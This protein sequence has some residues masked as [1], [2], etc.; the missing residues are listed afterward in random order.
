MTLLLATGS[1]EDDKTALSFWSRSLAYDLT[2]FLDDVVDVANVVVLD[3]VVDVAKVLVR[4]ERLL[5]P[6]LR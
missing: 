2:L 1:A 3:V 4:Y 6:R 5:V